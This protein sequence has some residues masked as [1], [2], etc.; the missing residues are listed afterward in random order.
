[1]AAFELVFVERRQ[2]NRD[3]LLL[4]AR[5]GEAK[6]DEL[7]VLVFDELHDVGHVFTHILFSI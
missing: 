2:R 3:V 7:D 1:M 4:A 6:V 5:V